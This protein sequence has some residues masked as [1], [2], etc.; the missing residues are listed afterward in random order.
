MANSPTFKAWHKIKC[1]QLLS[2]KRE[3]TIDEIVNDAMDERNL[4]IEE[5]SSIGEEKL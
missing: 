2:G 5:I 4:K 1:A 3:R